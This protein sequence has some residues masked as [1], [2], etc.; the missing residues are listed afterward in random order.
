MDESKIKRAIWIV[1]LL[2]G[3]LCLT[4]IVYGQA[5]LRVSPAEFTAT[6]IPLGQKVE[7]TS[8]LIMN[9]GVSAQDYAISTDV[10]LRYR[11]GY[12]VFPNQSWVTFDKTRI[13]LGPGEQEKVKVFLEIPDEKKYHAQKWETWINVEG[14]GE[15]IGV[16]AA[17]RMKMETAGEPPTILERMVMFIQ[18]EAITIASIGAVLS[19]ITA[20]I[21]VFKKKFEIKIKRK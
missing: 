15:M 16:A 7:V 1:S 10:P 11:E 3:I 13:T 9:T 4:S 18:E 21:Y 19:C 8:L 20:G 12:D 5:G 14:A 6:N 17:V 2:I